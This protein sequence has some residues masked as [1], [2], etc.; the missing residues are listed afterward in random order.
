M[1]HG[2]EI[3][4]CAILEGTD[5]HRGFAY[6]LDENRN[7]AINRFLG[8]DQ[9]IRDR[10]LK[11]DDQQSKKHSTKRRDQRIAKGG[12]DRVSGQFGSG[13]EYEGRDKGKECPEKTHV[14]ERVCKLDGVLLPK[15]RTIACIG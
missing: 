4:G 5:F 7:A 8:M 3:T 2:N 9:P 14:V 1:V 13:P 12:E 10:G 15:G 11:L 6:L